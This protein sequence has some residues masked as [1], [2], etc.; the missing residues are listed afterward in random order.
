MASG[1]ASFFFTPPKNPTT[2]LFVSFSW[3]KLEPTDK[4]MRLKLFS[5]F[6]CPVFHVSQGLNVQNTKKLTKV[7]AHNNI[8]AQW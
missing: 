4:V 1:I 6:V 2:K 3:T 8:E 7:L 5:Y